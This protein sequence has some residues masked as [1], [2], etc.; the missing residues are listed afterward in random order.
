MLAFARKQTIKAIV[1]D[2]NEAVEGL[3]RMLE[4]LIGEDINLAWM[5]AKSAGPVET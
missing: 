3:H 4:H 2:L 1:L 5:P